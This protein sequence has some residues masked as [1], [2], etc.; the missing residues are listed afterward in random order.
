MT[1][2][3]YIASTCPTFL[4]GGI[5]VHFGRVEALFCYPLMALSPILSLYFRKQRVA[6]F[7]VFKNRFQCGNVPTNYITT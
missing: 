4:K 3:V 5:G 2:I 7:T 6:I 1:H